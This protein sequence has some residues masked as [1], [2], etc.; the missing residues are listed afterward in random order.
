MATSPDGIAW[1]DHGQK[2]SGWTD[3]QP[4]LY[5]DSPGR[6]YEL[7]L[8]Y[9]Y[10][11]ENYDR[12]IRGMQIVHVD[13]QH[14]Q[15]AIQ[16]GK[17]REVPF[18]P[19]NTWY[20]DKIGKN[21]RYE[22]QIYALTRTYY[23]G[24]FLGLCLLYDDLAR[25]A[26]RKELLARDTVL[27]YLATSRDG[28]HFNWQW[29]YGKD[30]LPLQDGSERN[31]GYIE[32]AAQILTWQGCHWLFYTANPQSHARRFEGEDN[33]YL[34]QWPQDRLG[35]LKPMRASAGKVVTKAFA[36]P[37]DTLALTVNVDVE[38]TGLCTVTIVQDSGQKQSEMASLPIANVSGQPE[39]CFVFKKE[40]VQA[41]GKTRLVFHMSGPVKLFAFSIITERNKLPS[42]CS[43]G[44][45]RQR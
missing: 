3:T 24:I 23:E 40:E 26:G 16:A 31:Y 12:G 13:D 6:G 44:K 5:H 42:V 34:A 21:E 36:W 35:G 19:M 4:C 45:A 37:R 29:V 17:G 32:P 28:V 14:F 41:W 18:K 1:T 9:N 39:K 7:F 43:D 25:G 38:V 33:V 30:P 11:T 10:A 27:P 22:R 8:R 15:A 20:L 2:F